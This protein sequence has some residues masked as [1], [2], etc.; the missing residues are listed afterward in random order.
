M[1]G[2]RVFPKGSKYHY[3]SYLAGIWA[4]KVYTILLL[5]PFGFRVEGEGEGAGS[6]GLGLRITGF[7]VAGRIKS[8]KDEGSATAP[9]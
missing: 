5:G 2:K 6:W 4:P 3:S 9:G 7:G 1:R 8:E